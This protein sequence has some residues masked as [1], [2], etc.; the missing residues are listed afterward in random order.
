MNEQT[1][2][3]DTSA[4][5]LG[6]IIASPDGTPRASAVLLH[7][8]GTSGRPGNNRVFAR[9]SRALADAGVVVV[10]ADYPGQGA[11]PGRVDVGARKTDTPGDAE[12]AAD[13]MA[14]FRGR[15]PPGLDLLMIGS[16]YGA[17]LS[18]RLAVRQPA[19]K[20]LAL[21]APAIQTL[22]PEKERPGVGRRK[23]SVLRAVRRNLR[24]R[25]ARSEPQ[26]RKT[27]D[28]TEV[29]PGV[30]AAI[31]AASGRAPTWMLAG[32]LDIAGR[33]LP[34]LR[35]QLG[36]ASS[37]LEV[38]VVPNMVF[39]AYPSAEAQRLAIEKVVAWAGR[40]LNG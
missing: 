34:S 39:H 4:G 30:A 12:A 26:L 5:P 19:L 14:W 22:V 29:D 3:V 31:A 40:T 17:R 38:D 11:S 1:M 6:A 23:R 15:T 20:G 33:L 35:Q 27:P 9:M 13:L 10:R 8:G 21:M 24:P 37:R 16:C 25:T 7:G 36:D 2:L 32:E 18:S 28:E